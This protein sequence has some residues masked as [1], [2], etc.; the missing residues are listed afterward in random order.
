MVRT[1]VAAALCSVAWSGAALAQTTPAEFP[2]DSFAG[3]QYVDSNGCAFIRAG[4]SGVVNWVP[5]MNRQR[6]PLCGFEPTFGG[7]APVTE[8]TPVVAEEEAAPVV[9]ET[10]PVVEETVPVVEE[11]EVAA[12]VPSTPAVTEAVE[13]V[14]TVPATTTRPVATTTA[15]TPAVTQSPA[16]ITVPATVIEPV[17]PPTPRRMT[18]AE[19]CEGRTGVIAGFVTASGAPVDCGRGAAAAEPRRV[20]LSEICAE[21]AV[22]GQTFINQATGQPVAC[23]GTSRTTATATTRSVFGGIPASNPQGLTAR[24]V[25]PTAG[26][27]SAWDDGRVNPNRGLPPATTTTTQGLVATHSSMSVPAATVAPAT[28]AHRWVQVGSFG[29]PDNAARTATRLQSMGLPVAFANVTRNGQALRVVAAG[30]F[31]SAEELNRALQAA[32]SLGF[33]DAFTRR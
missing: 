19:A 6:E 20:T 14:A 31:A 29:D 15:T 5:R 13:T 10:A 27:R 17:V 1:Y 23:P 7:A 30:P 9:A 33:G 21:I 3:N 26:Y 32:R 28:T 22:T 12:V 4:I 24:D 18:L 11:A 8:A 2:P 16:V 25:Q